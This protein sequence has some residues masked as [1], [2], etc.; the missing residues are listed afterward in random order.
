[1]PSRLD[2]LAGC[3]YYFPPEFNE[4]YGE[5]T[6]GTLC[7]ETA[8]NSEVFTR[9]YSKATVQLDCKAWKGTITKKDH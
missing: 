8:T 3:R 1:M 5:P 6:D 7:K 4:D 9:E 2:S